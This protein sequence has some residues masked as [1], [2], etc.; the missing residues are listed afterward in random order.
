MDKYE[1]Y[2]QSGRFPQLAKVLAKRQDTTSDEGLVAFTREDWEDREFA[3][4]VI[5]QVLER[6]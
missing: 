4:Q 3:T 6:R 5:N 2:A 1:E